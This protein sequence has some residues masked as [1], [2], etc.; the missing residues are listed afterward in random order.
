MPDAPKVAAEEAAL[1]A[2]GAVDSLPEGE[3]A[4]KLQTA[5]AESR[6]LRRRRTS[7]SGTPSCWES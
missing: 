4:S 7:T 1:L 3:L 2:V 6:P 5:H